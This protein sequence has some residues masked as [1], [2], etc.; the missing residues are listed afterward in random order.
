MNTKLYFQP[1]L[2][3]PNYRLQCVTDNFAGLVTD[4]V[5]KHHTEFIHDRGPI[6]SPQTAPS[7]TLNT[8]CNRN[9]YSRLS[10][11]RDFLL[12][13]RF[14]IDSSVSPIFHMESTRNTEEPMFK[15]IKLHLS[16][17]YS[18][19]TQLE[20]VSCYTTPTTSEHSV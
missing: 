19:K 6:L 16:Y 4:S 9:A 13:L 10:F 15:Y 8:S 7:V 14:T 17:H 1:Y 20:T 5:P 11:D 12:L 3:F 18:V 2:F